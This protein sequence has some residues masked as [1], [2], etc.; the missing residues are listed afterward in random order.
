MNAA[1]NTSAVGRLLEEISWVGE[2]VRDYR[3][4]GQG[5][6]NVLTVEVFQSLDFLPRSVFLGEILRSAHGAEA[7]RQLVANEIEQADLTLLPGS[8]YYLIPS[9]SATHTKGLSVQPDG[10]MSSPNSLTLIEAKRIRSSSFQAEQLA[11]ELTL[12]AREAK[13]HGKTPLLFLILGSK[14]PIK[15]QGHGKVSI[16][17]SISFYLE[18]VLSRAENHEFTTEE[19]IDQI[20]ETVAWITWS[21]ISHI[22]QS[23]LSSLAIEDQSVAKCVNRLAQSITRSIE[24][25]K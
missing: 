17:D 6:E 19:L 18:S 25:H 24:W 2:N 5:Y 22:V 23:Q 3:K 4:G 1:E 8:N 20:P 12:V 11:R 7:V 13:A 9:K 16:T 15:V 14:P 10:M 21:E